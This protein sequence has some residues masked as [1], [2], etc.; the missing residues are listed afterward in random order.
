MISGSGNCSAP[1]A[2]PALGHSQ[3]CGFILQP[4]EVMTVFNVA[5]YYSTGALG[6]QLASS[7][8]TVRDD[9]TAESATRFY[10]S[11][12][13]GTPPI[14]YQ[15][16]TGSSQCLVIVKGSGSFGVITYSIDRN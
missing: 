16:L 15:N 13:T 4:N 6:T 11:L 7:E 5:L 10:S 8:L 3:Y 2:V 14:K 12:V 9:C 1:D